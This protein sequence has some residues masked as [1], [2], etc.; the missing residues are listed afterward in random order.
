MRCIAAQ[1]DAS[2]A[3]MIPLGQQQAPRG[4][5]LIGVIS[6]NMN[7]YGQMVILLRLKGHVP[8]TTERATRKPGIG[9]GR[10][11][12]CD[13]CSGIDA[14]SRLT[15]RRRGVAAGSSRDAD[16]RPPK[17]TGRGPSRGFAD[18]VLA[19]DSGDPAR[20][21]AAADDAGGAARAPTNSW[22]MKRSR[23]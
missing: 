15:H 16:T 7:E 12:R 1:T 14:Y 8:P 3:E 19:R 10:G 9:L 13:G 18:I 4:Q 23:S 20:P 21:R 11:A 6:H 22:P 17:P 2:L 5:A